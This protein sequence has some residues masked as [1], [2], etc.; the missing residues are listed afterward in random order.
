MSPLNY[1]DVTFGVEFKPAELIT[2]VC[3]K[4]GHRLGGT[5]TSEW[6]GQSIVE[7]ECSACSVTFSVHLFKETATALVV[8]Q[9]ENTAIQVG[10]YQNGELRLS[11]RS[12][13]L[14]ARL[15]NL[16]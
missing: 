3:R 11:S 6:Q 5:E 8:G 12:L 4:L 10:Y 13:L 2:I 7:F 14:C 15:T 1:N 9:I 16:F